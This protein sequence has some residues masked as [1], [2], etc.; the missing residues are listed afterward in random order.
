VPT[1]P[2]TDTGMPG[3]SAPSDAWRVVLLALG[4]LIASALILT[5]Q[6]RSGNRS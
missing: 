6:R 4:A 1:L 2:P 5:P 3:T